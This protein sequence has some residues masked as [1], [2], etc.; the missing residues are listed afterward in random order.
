VSHQRQQQERI[1]ACLRAK[2]K[3]TYTD[4]EPRIQQLDAY[5]S[6]L[7]RQGWQLETR[8]GGDWRTYVLMSEGKPPELRPPSGTFPGE[9]VD[10]QP[11]QEQ[12][13]EEE[14]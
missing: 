9:P 3:C 1:K 11:E 7:R 8:Y 12:L 4:F 14:E 6:D 13:F 5:V 2:G 10:V